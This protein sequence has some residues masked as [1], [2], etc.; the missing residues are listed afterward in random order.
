MS[1]CIYPQNIWAIV[2]AAG[3]SSRMGCTLEAE[4]EK[5]SSKVLIPLESSWT[6]LH[7]SL[8]QLWLS[9][10][11]VLVIPTKVE[12]IEEIN[13]IAIETG[14]WN[15][16]K[17]CQGGETR[18]DSV[19]NAVSYLKDLR[20]NT[21]CLDNRNQDEPI[22]IIHDAARPF[23]SVS[24][25]EKAIKISR[26]EKH[27]AVIG[28]PVISTIK[29]VNGE[30]F[31]TNTPL[32][33]KLW[34]AQTPQVFPFDNFVFAYE[35]LKNSGHIFYDDSSVYESAG[36]TVKI[37]RGEY[38]NLKVT[39]PIDIEVGRIIYKTIRLKGGKGSKPE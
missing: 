1:V 12:L 9:G 29:E 5:V 35:S 13:K 24:L 4:S 37:V 32:R 26:I 11:R 14:D 3:S 15:Y 38:Q 19:L 10:V 21:V 33:E 6:V 16:L 25:I 27:G 7:E 17:V 8:K 28:V 2:P 18:T 39:T 31:I 30:G 20:E 36:F 22:V 34:E 23:C